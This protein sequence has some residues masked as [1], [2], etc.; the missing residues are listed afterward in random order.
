M[1]L[2]L[3]AGPLLARALGPE[4]RGEVASAFVYFTLGVSVVGLGVPLAISHDVANAIHDRGAVLATAR[5]FTLWTVPVS[6]LIALVLI[7]GPLRFISGDRLGVAALLGALPLG[8]LAACLSLFLVGDGS[9]RDLARVQVVPVM[10]Q[11]IVTVTAYATGNLTVNSYLIILLASTLGAVVIAWRAIGVRPTSP[12]PLRPFVRFGLRGYGACLAMV[13]SLRLDQ[14]LLG[15][16]QGSQALGF[17]AVSVTLSLLPYTIARAVASRSFT[18]V[19]AL[20]PCR[21]ADKV[22]E[23]VR[24]T[25]LTGAVCAAAVAAV[26]PIMVP[27]L[28]GEVFSQ[29]VLPLLVLLPGVVLLCGSATACSSLVAVG[30]PGSSMRAEMAGLAVTLVGLPVVVPLFGI[31]GAAALSS[32]AYTVTFLLYRRELRSIGPT[33]LFP[34]RSDVRE[35]PPLL[36]G[37]HLARTPSGR[38]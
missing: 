2:G 9:L 31:I 12:L 16:L 19:A 33:R 36:L 18:V 32:G 20:E 22:S 11:T 17:Y 4:G 21:R 10:L 37:R 14:A 3:A 30:H 25:L 24:L 23:Y 13:G 6:I 35:L 5:R 28:Y 29:A 26:S 7:E 1:F 8:V 27:I 15:P 34:Q 38:A